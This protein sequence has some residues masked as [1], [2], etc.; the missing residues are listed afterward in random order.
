M[1]GDCLDSRMFPLRSWIGSL[2][3]FVIFL[4]FLETA[5]TDTNPFSLEAL[6]V[7]MFRVLKRVNHPVWTHY[8]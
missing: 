1:L 6:A 5:G 3:C 2:N 7:F 8:L 4:H